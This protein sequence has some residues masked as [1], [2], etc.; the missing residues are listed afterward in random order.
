MEPGVKNEL[1]LHN[2]INFQLQNW[3]LN[4]EHSGCVPIQFIANLSTSY[5]GSVAFFS[6]P[7]SY[8]DKS[9]VCLDGQVVFKLFKLSA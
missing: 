9:P 7:F 4:L 8:V 6:P 3:T 1:A 2:K 5:S